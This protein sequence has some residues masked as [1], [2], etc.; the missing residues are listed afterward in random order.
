MLLGRRDFYGQQMVWDGLGE[1]AQLT[2]QTRPFVDFYF[3][4]PLINQ[5][6]YGWRERVR[7]GKRKQVGENLTNVLREALGLGSK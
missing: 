7:F 5:E 3:N 2:T 4:G 1:G 6:V